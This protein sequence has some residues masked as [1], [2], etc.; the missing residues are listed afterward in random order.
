MYVLWCG[1]TW[2][3]AWS[4]DYHFLSDE[5]ATITNWEHKIEKQIISLDVTVPAFAINC[6]C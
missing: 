6:N 2:D 5:V 4:P 1:A 3:Q